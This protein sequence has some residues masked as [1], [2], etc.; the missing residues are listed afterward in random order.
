MGLKGSSD[1]TPQLKPKR[2]VLASWNQDDTY[3]VVF[4]GVRSRRDLSVLL[5]S[6]EKAFHI[7][8]A[9]HEL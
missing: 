9:K 5:K 3:T 2:S 7:K 6:A 1:T 4:D 8:Q